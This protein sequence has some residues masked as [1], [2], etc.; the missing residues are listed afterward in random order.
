MIISQGWLKPLLIGT[1]LG[2]SFSHYCGDN[3]SA[4]EHKHKESMGAG[5][6]RVQWR[7]QSALGKVVKNQKQADIQTDLCEKDKELVIAITQFA[8]CL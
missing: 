2:K 5:N 6:G 8:L 3:V 1:K 7:W 4:A